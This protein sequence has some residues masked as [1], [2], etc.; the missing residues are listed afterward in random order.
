MNSNVPSGS[1]APAKPG[2]RLPTLKLLRIATASKNLPNKPIPWDVDVDVAS[3]VASQLMAFSVMRAAPAYLSLPLQMRTPARTSRFLSPK[4]RDLAPPGGSLNLAALPHSPRSPQGPDLRGRL[5][6]IGICFRPSTLKE[7]QRP[8]VALDLLLGPRHRPKKNTVPFDSS[9]RR[10]SPSRDQNEPQAKRVRYLEQHKIALTPDQ[11]AVISAAGT[12]NICLVGSPGTGKTI[13]TEL[14]AIACANTDAPALFITARRCL[15]EVTQERLGRAAAKIEVHTLW[16]LEHQV[17]PSLQK[18]N[19]KLPGYSIII[20]DGFCDATPQMHT[21]LGVIY[22]EL[23]NHRPSLFVVGDERGSMSLPSSITGP[24]AR[25]FVSHEH[26]RFINEVY[27]HD[28]E[29]QLA[30][31]YQGTTIGRSAWGP[32]GLKPQFVHAEQDDILS[33]SVF[34]L[35]LINRFGA[36]NTAILTPS[37][38][39]KPDS[40]LPLLLNRLT[41]LGVPI[42]QSKPKKALR[43]ADSNGKVFV[44]TYQQFQ[45]CNRPLVFVFGTEAGYFITFGRELPRDRCPNTMLHALTRASQQLVVVHWTKY[46]VLPFIDWPRLKKSTPRGSILPVDPR[47]ACRLH[48]PGDCDDSLLHHLVNKYLTIDEL[49]AP[50]PDMDHINPPDRVYTDK[51]NGLSEDVSDLNGIMIMAGLKFRRAGDALP[52]LQQLARKAIQD[53]ADRSGLVQRQTAMENDPC[54]WLERH[55]E[56][57]VDRLAAQFLPREDISLEEPLKKYPPRIWQVSRQTERLR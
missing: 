42:T 56:R 53:Q 38:K 17:L 2:L 34:V 15:T 7:R 52:P 13:V 28:E 50:L 44:G 10:R 14:V 8:Q 54:I 3:C 21:I 24:P 40:P 31:S 6:N 55:L 20:V 1:S 47:R 39:Y 27:L 43:L 36:Q 16:T 4:R 48:I 57:A 11:R 19:K 5:R 18:T 35:G 33:L 32:Q 29:S 51:A 46:S 45:G 22:D 26:A 41:K 9:K 37:V 23:G 49:V 25:R 30:G 12:V